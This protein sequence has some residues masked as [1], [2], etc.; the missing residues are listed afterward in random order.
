MPSYTL[1]E[2]VCV[3][4]AFSNQFYWFI[5]M[6]LYDRKHAKH[7]KRTKFGQKVYPTNHKTKMLQQETVAATTTV[8]ANRLSL[9][10]YRKE[11]DSLKSA[12]EFYHDQECHKL[13]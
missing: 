8:V 13:K 3:A 10:S 4:I 6:Y 2:I 11:D 5:K 7:K 1:L 9:E 12:Q